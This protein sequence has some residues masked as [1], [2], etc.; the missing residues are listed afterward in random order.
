MTAAADLLRERGAA[1]VTTRAVAQAADVSAPTIFRLF[2]DKDGL[3]EAV[4]E[5][6]MAVHAA[7]K[8]AA[9]ADEAGDPV[10][11]LRAAWRAQVDFGLANPDLYVLLSTPGRL[12]HSP[13]VAAGAD[14]LAARIARIA[15]AG[16]LRV[17]EARA[18]AMVHAAGTG[19]VLALLEQP[20][21]ARVAGLAD[22]T[23]DAVLGAV[24]TG[25]AAPAV[26]D[27]AALAV[28]FAA[29]VPELPGLSDAERALMREWLE[30]VIAELED[31]SSGARAH[32]G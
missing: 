11:D 26:S 9:A 30:R 27:H 8:A 1:A 28:A 13:A 18:A 19:V 31:P 16:R 2:G 22:A 29:A 15:V 20:E 24:A 32:R 12:Q 6:V 25:T 3:L 10:V 4:A 14:V 17:S 23:I 7:E 21:S 5:H